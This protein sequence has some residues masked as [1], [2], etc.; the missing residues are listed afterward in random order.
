MHPVSP[1]DAAPRR[2]AGGL[3]LGCALLAMLAMAHHPHAHGG[4]DR[5]AAL[6]RIAGPNAVVH[7]A[8][9]VL[10]VAL[11]VLLGEFAAARI[12]EAA[13]ARAGQVLFL[14]GGS[15]LV[16]AA[17]VNGFA[18]PALAI[19]MAGQAAGP[20]W[21]PMLRFAWQLNQAASGFGVLAWA[22]GI[23]VLSV[24]L[25]RRRGPSRWV[26]VYGLVAGAAIIAAVGS[27]QV[28]LDVRGFGIV[29]FALCLWQAGAGVLMLR[30]APD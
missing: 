15:A 8:L 30:R 5:L 20:E 18:V 17:L 19:S 23:A 10:L 11:V 7:G 25:V 4:G 28:A 1:N 9:L 12:R 24:D 26:G 16:L 29:L 27:H 6:A 3:L 13:L 14:L 21:T 2:L 22:A